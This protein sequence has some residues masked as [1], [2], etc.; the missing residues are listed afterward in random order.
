MEG[1]P[2][3]L[4]EH[5]GF[6]GLL[7]AQHLPAHRRQAGLITAGAY[8]GWFLVV[9]LAPANRVGRRALLPRVE[10]ELLVSFLFYV[11]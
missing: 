9:L 2:R 5:E 3:L 7:V 1:L 11:V 8:L 6:L 4:R 10:E